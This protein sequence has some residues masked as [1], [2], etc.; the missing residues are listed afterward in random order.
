[1]GVGSVPDL[2]FDASACRVVQ[3]A[4]EFAE[5]EEVVALGLE[6]QGRVREAIRS[7]HAN[8]VIQK[9][10]EVLPVPSLGFI[11]EEMLGAGPEVARHRYGCR[12]L[13]RLV[14]RHF[15]RAVAHMDEL[16]KE[17]LADGAKVVRHSF[18][19]HVIEMVLQTG[20]AY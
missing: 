3:K 6:L 2:A 14:E 17:L 13:C 19:H 11:A 18:G 10:V 12:V 1:M 8:H 5:E 20:N 7:P 4:L 15:A 9:L 16:I